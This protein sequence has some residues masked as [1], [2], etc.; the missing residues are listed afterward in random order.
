MLT[1]KTKMK[2]KQHF[3]L[4]ALLLLFTTSYI[5]Q[6]FMSTSTDPRP[7]NVLGTALKSCCSDPL[8]GYYRDGFCNTGPTDYGTHVVC[9]VMTKE[10]LTYTLEQGNDLS[11]PRPEYS[12]P[13]LTPGDKWCLCASRWKEALLDGVAPPVHLE[14]TH[15]KALAFVSLEKLK[16]HA[17]A[18]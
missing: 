7:K 11:T 4:I 5:S 8:T 13:G 12:F 6:N 2:S 14:A 15:E 16:S 17:V 9:A 10:F 18:D 1:I 3:S